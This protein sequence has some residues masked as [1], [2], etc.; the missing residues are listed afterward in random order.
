MHNVKHI[1]QQF[2]TEYLPFQNTLWFTYSSFSP[3]QIPGKKSIVTVPKTF[4][5]SSVQLNKLSDLFNVYFTLS[6]LILFFRFQNYITFVPSYFIVK[7]CLYAVTVFF[8]KAGLELWT[9]CLSLLCARITNVWHRAQLIVRLLRYWNRMFSKSTH[10]T[11][12]LNSDDMLN[13]YTVIRILT[14]TI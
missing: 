6:I 2:Q 3:L 9:S 11:F 1:A 12:L 4:M 14:M 7:F 13:P 10:K 5:D 8:L